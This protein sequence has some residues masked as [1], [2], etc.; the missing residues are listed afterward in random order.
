MSKYREGPKRKQVSVHLT[1]DLFDEVEKMRETLKMNT[2]QAYLA[3]AV[4][5]YTEMH[6]NAINNGHE[7]ALQ[8][9]YE[10]AFTCDWDQVVRK[11]K[12][13]NQ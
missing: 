8:R 11:H 10:L 7:G 13:E 12:Q 9:S 3:A 5:F 4:A 1:L 2:R 6:K